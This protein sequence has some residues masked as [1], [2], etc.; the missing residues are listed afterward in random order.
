MVEKHFVSFSRSF[1]FNRPGYGERGYKRTS[2]LS[3]SGEGGPYLWEEDANTSVPTAQIAMLYNNVCVRRSDCI[4][5]CMW[6]ADTRISSG[7]SLFGGTS[8]RSLPTIY[9]SVSRVSA[10]RLSR[11][12]VKHLYIKR[13]DLPTVNNQPHVSTP[14]L[15]V[16][17]SITLRM[18]V[19]K[20]LREHKRA[21]MPSD[22]VAD[23]L[24]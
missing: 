5:T 11:S 2:F 9:T 7:L 17:A 16:R 6:A 4:Y 22:C 14:R 20:R 12:A 24:F 18:N 23:D 10:S 13:R 19:C 15:P 21:S 3:S 1:L 8:H